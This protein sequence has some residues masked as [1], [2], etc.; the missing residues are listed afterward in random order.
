[1]G[2][3]ILLTCLLLATVFLIALG[4]LTLYFAWFVSL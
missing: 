2:D 3:K 1:V 4:V